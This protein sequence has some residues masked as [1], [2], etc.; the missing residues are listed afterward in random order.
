MTT[1]AKHSTFLSGLYQAAIRT[2]LAIGLCLP[3][4]SCEAQSKLKAPVN[5]AFGLYAGCINGTI[6]ST[7]P[8]TRK[9]VKDFVFALD[10]YCV[11]WTVIWYSTQEDDIGR[12]PADR[13]AR[14]E[15]LR[16]DYLQVLYT[17]LMKARPK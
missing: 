9:E 12:W 13:A 4:T 11:Q 17:S 2:S 6:V 16:A 7:Q 1:S 10:K 14:F 8:E 5:V 3:L 15:K